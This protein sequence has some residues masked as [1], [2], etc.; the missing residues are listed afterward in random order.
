M[1]L[2]HRWEHQT[3]TGTPPLGIAYY[4][5][6]HIGKDIFYFGGFCGHHYCYHNSLFSLNT[7]TLL[8]KKIMRTRSHSGPMQ[9]SHCGLLAV[10]NNLISIGGQCE[11]NPSNRSPLAKYEKFDDF[12]Y[13]NEVHSFD[14][15]R[16]EYHF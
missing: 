10:N 12:T 9:K 1:S 7:Q 15:T 6:C 5:S 13:T 3:T 8:W 2:I 14:W 11:G 4:A 16:G